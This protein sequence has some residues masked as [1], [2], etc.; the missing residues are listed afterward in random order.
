M[1]SRYR[2]GYVSFNWYDYIWVTSPQYYVNANVSGGS[3]KINYYF[4]VGHMNQESAIRN[5]GGMKRYNVQMNVEAQVT[6]KFKIGMN[7]NGRIK[8]L[9]IRVYRELTTIQTRQ[10]LPTAIYRLSVRCQ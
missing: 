4:S 7:M 9:K 8:Q 3:D 5:Y 6:D 1:A 10:Q 2:K